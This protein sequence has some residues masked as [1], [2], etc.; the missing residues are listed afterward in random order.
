[1]KT[2]LVLYERVNLLSFSQI[3]DFLKKN[4]IDFKIV[5]FHSQTSDEYGYKINSDI[6]NESLFGYEVVF[7]P[8]GL[9]ALNLRYDDIFLSWIKTAK[10]AKMKIGV[11]LGNL[12]LGGAGF[13]KDKKSV[14]RGGYINALS[15]YCEH[16]EGNFYAHED[17]VSLLDNKEAWNKLSEILNG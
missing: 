16:V 1:M 9:G 10:A 6:S 11:D 13:L 4:K 5:S 17:M 12:I 7:L 8:N 3:Y 14:I 2:C 15:E